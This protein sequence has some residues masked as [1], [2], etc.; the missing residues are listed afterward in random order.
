MELALNFESHVGRPLLPTPQSRFTG[1]EMSLQEKGRVIRLAVTLLGRAAGHASILPA[2]ITTRCRALVPLGAGML[3]GVKGRQ[4]FTRPAAVWHHLQRL[5]QYNSERW[6]RQQQQRLARRQ[7]KQRR[8]QGKPAASPGDRLGQRERCPGKGGAK[9]RAGAY[10][11]DFYVG[12]I[13]PGGPQRPTV[14]GGGTRGRP[15]TKCKDSAILAAKA[16]CQGQTPGAAPLTA[17]PLGLCD[18]QT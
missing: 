3:V 11:S 16:L 6:V 5:H 18:T 7:H 13:I 8:V 15:H 9:R 1:S 14:P 12:P 2:A 4:L 17:T 10:A